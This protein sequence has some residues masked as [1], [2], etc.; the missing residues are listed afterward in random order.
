MIF[1]HYKN[2]LATCKSNNSNYYK[3]GAINGLD[4]SSILNVSVESLAAI[5]DNEVK[6]NKSI[7]YHISSQSKEISFQS[8]SSGELFKGPQSNGFPQK[9]NQTR[10]LRKKIDDFVNSLLKTNETTP[11]D[12]Q[13]NML[14]VFNDLFDL[15]EVL[16]KFG[17][18]KVQNIIE[19]STILR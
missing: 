3:F 18:V 4:I 1:E 13:Q 19:Y 7:D 16:I 11:E 10:K 15:E 2:H 17:F 8:A 5:S 12:L 14:H 9:Y 6:I